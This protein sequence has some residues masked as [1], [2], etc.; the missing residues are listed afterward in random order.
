MPLMTSLANISIDD[1]YLT[2]VLIQMND[3]EDHE[4]I[5]NIGKAFELT[6]YGG[7]SIY[8]AY[9]TIGVNSKI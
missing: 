4:T 5:E 3:P 8:L 2:N 7:Q 1:M 9:K 6:N